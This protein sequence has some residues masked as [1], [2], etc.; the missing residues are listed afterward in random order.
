MIVVGSNWPRRFWVTKGLCKVN[1][2][3]EKEVKQGA[4]N[5]S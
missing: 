5:K 3:Q 1:K 4:P 2:R